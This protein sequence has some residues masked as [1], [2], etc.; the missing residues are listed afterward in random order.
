MLLRHLGH[1]SLELATVVTSQC[2]YDDVRHSAPWHVQANALDGTIRSVNFF[3]E[4]QL[5][6]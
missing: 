4:M 6:F 5:T 3:L 2:R 1:L